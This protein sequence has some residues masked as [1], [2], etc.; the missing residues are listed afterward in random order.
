MIHLLSI[1]CR[2]V[3]VS[4]CFASL[5]PVTCLCASL[6]IRVSAS[7]GTM[8]VSGKPRTISAELLIVSAVAATVFRQGGS[9]VST[10]SN[11]EEKNKQQVCKQSH[12]AE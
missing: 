1:M 3:S 2:A 9:P 10:G 7:C 5:V 11:L 4:T 8:T 12:G 6:V